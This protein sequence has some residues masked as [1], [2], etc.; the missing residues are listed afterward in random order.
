[1][2]GGPA[3]QPR[4]RAIFFG[5]PEL[6]VP[7]LQALCEIADV[8]LVVTQPDRP[9]GRGM[10]LTPPPVKLLAR[11][12]GIEVVQPTKLRTSDFAQRL[13]AL[14]ADVAVVVAYGR[15]LPTKVLQAPRLGCVNVHASLL[16]R[17]RGAAPIQWA[18]IRG[19]RRTGAC[20]MQMNE[21]M[22][23]GP[24][25]ACEA[26]EIAAEETAGELS[27]RLS[28][29]G[30]QLVRE[31][32]PRYL[33]GEL[34]AKPQE[35][36]LA[37]LA[38]LL[39]KEDGQVDWCRCAVELHDLV[40]G[41]HP[42]P[43]AYTFLEG[44]RV[45]LHRVRVLAA[46]GQH[47]EPGNVVRADRHGIEVACGSGVLAIDELQPEGKKR[48]SAEQFCAGARLQQSTRFASVLDQP[49]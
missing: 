36:A 15:I 46:E 37:T 44:V 30:E 35:P 42:W 39:K 3:D 49:P 45:K 14:C 40:R 32:V 1:V 34:V 16:P 5:T 19:E 29:L 33:R 7:C 12:R 47:A 21:G 6:A 9:S 27:A 10:K 48:M 23:E 28:R 18:I 20:L 43:G 26:L 2:T 22:D 31:Q 41:M 8:V 4:A 13:S 25:L 11:A 38:P 17:L 24:V